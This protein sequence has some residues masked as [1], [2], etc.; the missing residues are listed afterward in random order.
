MAE[1]VAAAVTTETTVTEPSFDCF[2]RAG[3][4]ALAVQTN[5]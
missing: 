2:L 3:C 5:C 1:A 4:R